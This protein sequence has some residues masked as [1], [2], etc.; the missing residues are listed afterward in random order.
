M[1]NRRRTRTQ[2]LLDNLD[3]RS[4]VLLGMMGSGKSAIGKMLAR[5]LGIDFKDADSEI[6]TAAGR[7]VSEIFEEYGEEEFRRLETRVIDRILN[8]GP[9]LL[10]LGGGAFMAKSTRETVAESAISVWIRADL[11]LL[12]ERVGRRPGKRPLLKTGNPRKILSD[13]LEI[14]E[15]VYALA[16]IHVTSKGGTKAEMRDKIFATMENY[17][18]QQSEKLNS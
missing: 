10:A 7:S 12:L 3:G 6:E 17:F 14:R 18:T 9:V 5:K 8:E 15:P 1:K 13:L 11:E 2:R 4:I 16:D